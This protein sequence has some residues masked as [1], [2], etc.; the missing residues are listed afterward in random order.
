MTDWRPPFWVN[1]A[2]LNAELRALGEDRPYVSYESPGR[3]IEEIMDIAGDTIG[4][5]NAPEGYAIG[6]T[7]VRYE[8]DADDVLVTVFRPD[9]KATLCSHH[10]SWDDYA[11]SEALGEILSESTCIEIAEQVCRVANDL[12]EHA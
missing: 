10:L 9:N 7:V 3:C 11:P 8:S 4:A 2:A 1:P 6:V 12:L 5:F